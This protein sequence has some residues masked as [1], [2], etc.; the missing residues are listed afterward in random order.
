M[1]EKTEL[2]STLPRSVPHIFSIGNQVAA[3][4]KINANTCSGTVLKA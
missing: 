1:G 3:H 4:A 2:F